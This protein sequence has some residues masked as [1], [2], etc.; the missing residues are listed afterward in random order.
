MAAGSNGNHHDAHLDLMPVNAQGNATTATHVA[1]NDGDWFDPG[2][3]EGGKVPW[4]GALVHIKEGVS[5]DYDGANNAEL[6]IVR[7]DGNLTITAENGGMT[8]MIV[9]TMIT[10]PTS[11]L[12][13]DARDPS[14]GTI[15]IEFNEGTPNAFKGT[16]TDD[17]PGDGVIG[18]HDWDPEQ[19]SLGL[20]ASGAVDIKGHDID[21]NAQLATGPNAGATELVLDLDLGSSGW[22]VGQQIVVGGVKFFDRE[23]GQP[24]QTQDEVRTITDLRMEAGKMVVEF[25]QPLEFDHSGPVDP[26][27]GLELTGQVGNL[28]RNV[29]I[30]SAVADENGDGLV[31]RG[32]SLNET[33][34]PDEHYVTERGHIMFM[35]ND[36]VTVHDI[37]IQ[38]LGRTDKSVLVDEVQTGGLH[39]APLREIGGERNVFE[40]EL[41]TVLMTPADQIENHRGRYA[42]HL[43]M[44]NGHGDHGDHDDHDHHMTDG[45]MGPCPETGGPMCFCGDQD[46]DGIENCMDDDVFDGAWIEGVAV[47]GTPGWGI[48]Q[49]STD[50][51][52]TNNVVFDAA[53]SA[54]VSETGD[55]TGRWEGNL[56]VGTYGARQLQDN[57]DSEHFNGDGGASGNGFYVK[58]RAIEV[59]DNVA[60]SSARAGFMWHT[61][62]GEVI[63]PDADKLGDFEVTANHTEKVEA[64]RVPIVGFEG[65]SVIAAQQGIRLLASPSDS[66]RKFND[67]YS[68]LKDFTAWEID[69]EGV[70]IT[71]SSK[72][73]FENFLLLGTEVKQTGEAQLTNSGFYF[74]ASVADITVVDSH[75]EHFNHA[76]TNW[77]QVG[78]R[79]EYRRGYWD[80]KFPSDHHAVEEYEGMGY[81]EG[82]TNVAH[83]LWNTNIVGLTYDDIQYGAIRVPSIN[84][85]M[86][87]GST[88][89]ERG[90][91]VLNDK[92][93]ADPSGAMIELVGDSRDGGLVALWREDIADH[94]NQELMLHQHIPLAYQNNVYLDQIQREDGTLLAR[95]HY[96]DYVKGI[97]DD[98][99]S[100]T[101]LEF[102]KTDSLGR[103]VFTYGDFSPM[104]PGG[105]TRA[106]ST[107]ERLVFSKDEI[108]ATLKAEGYY[109]IRGIDDVKFVV[110][111][112]QFSDRLTGETDT[113]EILVAL[114]L[115]WQLPEGAQNRG[116]LYIHDEMLIATQYN[117]FN[118]G[119]LVADRPPI[120][121]G[122]PRNSDMEYE[123]GFGGFATDGAD[124][125]SLGTG[126]D[127]VSAGDGDDIV[128]GFASADTL[129]G[130]QGQDALFGGAGWDRLT[131][132]DGHDL[133]DGDS[134]RDA[135]FGGN[136]DDQL[137]GGLGRDMLDGGAGNDMISGGNGSDQAFGGLGNDTI[138]GGSG[139]DKLQGGE[140]DDHMSGG[141]GFDT[142][143]GGSG[144]DIISG[145]QGNDLLYGGEGTDLMNGGARADRLFGGDGADLLLGDAGADRLHG[146]DGDDA[147][148]GQM[149][150]DRLFGG[151]GD[152]G[153]SGDAG[154]DRLFGGDGDD[155]L[156]GGANDDRLSGGDGIDTFVFEEENG[157]DVI[158]DFEDGVDAIEFMVQSFGFDD[159]EIL[160]DGDDTVIVYGDNSIRLLD[161]DSSTITIDDISFI[162]SG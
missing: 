65:N 147:L 6:F 145:N 102:A 101:I 28:S 131:G 148:F 99:W 72:Y 96:N 160:R 127:V 44:A 91:L 95:F 116:L 122:P 129:D 117:V 157:K 146:D 153:L 50:A 71:Y 62:G 140:G 15:D 82:I 64:E 126:T 88:V 119:V 70:S 152:D 141:L 31:D 80:P 9:D 43:H 39:T 136:G 5:V 32:V 18:R 151:S 3:W 25:D 55:E 60:H 100:G 137:Q 19:L 135:L 161:T 109:Q 13:V 105:I 69:A 155:R 106:V 11:T 115:A 107:N 26:R 52:L 111:R 149:G 113:V 112:E 34:G 45:V 98:I 108:D 158:T 93:D 24:M 49:H 133:L 73:I 22:E 156:A 121:L 142:M 46:G 42:L 90:L 51:V 86:P 10:S 74:K 7:V 16:Y 75:V 103:Q 87:D 94:P 114:D 59:T 8:K 58:S 84:I 36:N 143:E 77:S 29:T 139:G 53:G 57:S 35:H 150:T 48:V 83:N 1:V 14:A 47:W 134:Q 4:H 61:E 33:L 56:A 2:T 20:V 81:A 104:D 154:D 17:S 41:D 120:L 66:V 12:I 68:H 138:D 54:F 92:D 130:G 63:D 125:L 110:I 67:V 162:G 132:G 27:T 123:S 159:L 23:D 128:R 21:S 118:N 124:N 78:D 97:N 37:A 144:D 40:E 85:D 30:K 89:R 38:G 79:Q 76:V